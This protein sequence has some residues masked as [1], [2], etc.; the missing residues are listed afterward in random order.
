MSDRYRIEHGDCLDLLK[1]E[2]AN[3]WD[4]MVTDPPGG[5]SFMSRGWDG[6][7]GGRKQWCS[8]MAK[9]FKAALR[10]LK[11][12][13]HAFVWALPRTSHWT[14]CALEDAGFEI[15]DCP[16]HVFGCLSDDTE[17]LVNGE[18]R[19]HRDLKIGDLALGYDAE[20]NEYSWQPIQKLYEY[21]YAD[22]AFRIR[23]DS[24]DQL[25]SRGH[26]CLVERGGSYAFQVAETL[27][28]EARVPVLEDLP[29]L[30]AAL[31]V[32]DQRAGGA[33]QHVRASLCSGG[34]QQSQQGSVP[35]AGGALPGVRRELSA[36]V[37]RLHQKGEV[38]LNSLLGEGS[39]N[40]RSGVE[41]AAG[42]C[43]HRT[44]GLDGSQQSYLRG[45]DVGSEESGLEG[46]RD[47]QTQQRE[48]RGP[49]VCALP[50]GVLGNGAEGRLRDGASPG[51]RGTDRTMPNARGVGA[52]HRSRDQEQRA[53][54]PDALQDEPRPQAVRGARFTRSDLATVQ[55]EF[56]RGVVWCVSVPTRAFV[57]RRNGKVFVTGNSGFPKS[58]NLP[59]GLGTALKPGHEL[60][61]LVRKPLEGTIAQNYAKYGTGVLNIDACRVAAQQDYRDKCASVVGI[62]SPRNSVAYGEYDTSEGREDSA[63]DAGRWPPNLLLTH[64]ARCRCIGSR[65]VKANPTWDTPNRDTAPSAFTGS[66]ISA[67]RHANGR[68]GEASADKRYGAGGSN[69][70]AA[71]PGQR[72]DD[73]EDVPVWECVEGCPVLLLDRQSGERANGLGFNGAMPGQTARDTIG[74]TGTA[75]RFFPQFEWNADL[76]DLEPFIYAAKASRGERD[77]GLDHF[78][79]NAA[80]RDTPNPGGID[81]GSRNVHPT[82]KSVEL[83]R[84]LIRLV[85]PPRTDGRCKVGSIFMGSGTDG[86]ATLLEGC[87][88]VGFELNDTD[89][90]PF[91]SIA[92]ARCEHALGYTY[93]PRE[94]LRTATPPA[95]VGLFDRS[96]ETA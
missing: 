8:F 40:G 27:E 69:G 51:R 68:D 21:A 13:A 63:N 61:F 34:G 85:T 43:A 33:E 2:S 72:R 46:R 58:H 82:V 48:L 22:T 31:P 5:I 77:K 19:F 66:E 15:R 94:S 71:T 24:T 60:W 87:D 90:E 36:E 20:R 79:G 73:A 29:G 45:S 88:F 18:W 47:L 17:I 38:L 54:Q 74:D 89:A 39:S 80:Q 91:V 25:V 42:S 26:R 65:A 93:V 11:P 86:V 6:D 64:D 4:A 23:S 55:P 12:G 92:R 7:K 70:F 41:T 44:S 30:L 37:E 59:G 78:K 28:R 32:L 75:S 62:T 67:V 57:A 81:A 3:S 76:D 56:Y 83:M 95:Q 49:E 1:R 35:D 84:Y 52:S 50:V 9:R 14:G 10:V 96:R 53:G 16:S